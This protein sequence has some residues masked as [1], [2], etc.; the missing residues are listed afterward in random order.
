MKIQFC[1]PYLAL[2]IAA[3]YPQLMGALHTPDLG[4]K[5]PELDTATVIGISIAITGNVLISLALNL[6]K[7]AHKRGAEERAVSKDPPSHPNGISEE[8]EDETEPP[9]EATVL[10]SSNYGSTS[11]DTLTTN[12]P[13]KTFVSRIF[14]PK[15][16]NGAVSERA[17]LLP[18]DVITEEQA[19]GGRRPRHTR[20]KP[21]DTDEEGN[22]SDYLK[23]K[24][25]WA[26]FALMNI[27][28]MGNFISYAWAPAS[29]V[30]PLGTF[31]LMANC[32]FAP[33]MLGEK[34]R[35][36]DIFGIMIA[37]VGAVTVVLASNAS[38][39]RLDPDALLKAITRTPFLIYSGTYIIGI[40]ILAFLSETIGKQSVF[41]DV[42]L[43]ALFGGFTVLS[44][45][46]VSTLLTMEFLEMFTKWITYPTIAVLVLTGLGQI[47]YLNRA[48][49]RFDG[50]VVIPV[51]FVF[52][53]ISCIVGSAVLYGDFK[54]A[55]FHQLV[56]FLYGC[57]A[58]FAGV[59]IIA[60]E[61]GRNDPEDESLS[62]SASDP[63]EESEDEESTAL[64]TPGRRSRLTLVLPSG[65]RDHHQLIHKPSSVSMLALSPARPLLMV[66]TPPREV[67]DRLREHDFEP[68]SS[69]RRRA[70]SYM[71]DDSRP[72][73]GLTSG[74]LTRSDIASNSSSPEQQR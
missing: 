61:P 42:G 64:G 44:T 34:F 10:V 23:S 39:T 52:F 46:A 32:V 63:H 18:V 12:T 22:E 56:T 6:Q 29:V 16:T 3:C 24:I 60:Y 14:R 67:P 33:L 72:R 49:M 1:T 73:N 55:T 58:T 50:K 47:R 30:A 65:V 62:E 74:S 19:M 25:W 41:V 17:T 70:I 2:A 59:F 26:G 21:E 8:A 38:D 48:L 35:K 43:C 45:K 15:R 53:T 13:K 66:H 11:S 54:K 51:Q 4:G 71:G 20:R 27:G 37:V 69:S 5:L 31:A 36:R 28:E 68:I 7:L 40:C 57:A 9:V